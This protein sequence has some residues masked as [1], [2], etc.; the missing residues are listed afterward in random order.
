LGGIAVAFP[1]GSGMLFADIRY[2]GDL[3]EPKLQNGLSTYRRNMLSISI[4]Y[5][6]GFFKKTGS[7]K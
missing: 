4:G 2:A 3:G 6:F 7:A 1:V 5:E